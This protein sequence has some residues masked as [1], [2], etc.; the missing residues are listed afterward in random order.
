MNMDSPSHILI[1]RVNLKFEVFYGDQGPEQELINML[2]IKIYICCKTLSNCIKIQNSAFKNQKTRRPYLSAQG[3]RRKTI[4][5]IK[6]LLFKCAPGTS[7]IQAIVMV[8]NNRC[9]LVRHVDHY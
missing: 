3:D 9:L 7:I 2:Q 5:V 6:V 8:H 1:K 4:K